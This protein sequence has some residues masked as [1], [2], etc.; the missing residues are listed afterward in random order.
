MV[1][2]K[3]NTMATPRRSN[4]TITSSQE[5]KKTIVTP[6]KHKVSFHRILLS[7]SFYCE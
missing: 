7:I 3:N 5:K 2:K 1:K 4:R 6:V